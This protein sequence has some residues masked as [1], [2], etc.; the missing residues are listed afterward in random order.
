MVSKFSQRFARRARALDCFVVD[1]SNVHYALNIIIIPTEHAT[2]PIANDE[3][4]Q[5]TNMGWAVN[6]WPAGVHFDRL[7]ISGN[8]SFDISSKSIKEF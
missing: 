2:E 8:K 6:G 3:G 1:I 5:I 4:T 7:R